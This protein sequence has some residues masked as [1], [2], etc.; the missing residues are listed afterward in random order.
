MGEIELNEADM[1][2]D[3]IEQF[4]AWF[5]AAQSCGNLQPEA[6]AL[7]T[8]TPDGNPSVRMALLKDFDESG[9]VFFTNYRS[10]KSR[11]LASNA[12]AAMVFFWPELHRQVRIEGRVQ[13]TGEMESDDYF[14]SRPI[15]SQWSAVASPQSEIVESRTI[16]ENEVDRVRNQYPVG[17]VPRP[18]Y[19]GGFRL[20]PDVI[21]FWQGR[22]GRLHD[23]ICYQRSKKWVRVRLAP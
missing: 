19:W 5:A 10:R 18:D 9:F 8:A 22:P 6:M 16:L 23:R 2:A 21:E 1:S 14:R 3:P 17:P 13:R 20:L 12:R 4:R 15:E 7:A 11:E